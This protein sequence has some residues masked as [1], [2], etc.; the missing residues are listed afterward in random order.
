MYESEKEDKKTDKKPDKKA[1]PKKPTKIDLKNFNEL[2]NKEE[3]GVNRELFKI[4]CN[5]QRPSDMLKAAYNTNDNEKNR[6]LVNV[7]RSGLSD[8]KNET[9]IEKTDKIVDVVTKIL[10][11][12]RQNQEDKD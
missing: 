6:D 4:F 3:M 9:E 8:L 1:P 11:F 10:Q 7:I 12:N 5:F 2:I